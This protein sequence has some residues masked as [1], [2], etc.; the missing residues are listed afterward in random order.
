MK[1]AMIHAYTTLNLGDDLFIKVLTERYPN[2]KFYLYAPRTYKKVFSNQ[3]NLKIIP[4]N[5]IFIKAINF[6]FRFFKK[7][8]VLERYIKKSNVNIVIG[9]SLFMET[10]NWNNYY[11]HLRNLSKNN[12]YI[13]GANFGPYN[14]TDFYKKYYSLFS[15]A[16]DVCFRDSFSHS[17]YNEINHVRL[18][19]D[20][21]FQLKFPRDRKVQKKSV[22]ISIIKPSFRKDYTKDDDDFYYS[23]IRKIIE[24]FI[25]KDYKVKIFSF[26]SFE[27]D[28][29]AIVEILSEFPLNHRV[30]VINY[31]GDISNAL[32]EIAKSEIIIA[33]R[34][35]AMILGFL[36][37]KFVL[38]ITYSSKMNNFLDDINFK[39][40]IYKLR[41]E[42]SIEQFLGNKINNKINEKHLEELV[43]DSRQF[44]GLD[45]VLQ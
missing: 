44:Q 14:S 31:E 28:N 9:G 11:N 8:F 2:T 12:L 25:S 41:D 22:L 37:N 29:E 13:L 26:C 35:H 33:T 36:F 18:A 40:Y 43:N 4:S 39:G 16:K 42:I 38:P 21:V 45:K 32:N 1:K 3:K 34:F 7:G 23:Q 6:S 10:D 17:L 20:I 30:E 5:S 24:L 15:D 19:S 27:K